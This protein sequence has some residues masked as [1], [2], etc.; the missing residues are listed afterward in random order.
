MVVESK[1]ISRAI[2]GSACCCLSSMWI[3]GGAVC[4]SLPNPTSS[5]LWSAPKSHRSPTRLI[6]QSVSYPTTRVSFRQHYGSEAD[7]PTASYTPTIVPVET[8]IST[9]LLQQHLLEGF[10]AHRTLLNSMDLQPAFEQTVELITSNSRPN[11]ETD[12]A[13]E[14]Q[15][16]SPPTTPIISVLSDVWKARLLLLLS[17]ALYGTNFTLVKSIDEINGMSVGMASTLRFG[18]AALAMLPLLFAPIDAELKLMT[19]ERRGGGG[20]DGNILSKF[21]EEPTRLSAG[22]AGMEIGLYNSIGYLAQAVGLKTTTASKVSSM[23]VFF[24]YY[25]F[26]FALNLTPALHTNVHRVHSFAQWRWLLFRF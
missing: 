26:L 11:D 13:T 3:A 8:E 15:S 6:S 14:Q 25:L 21:W 19:K 24:V 1:M 20:A 2:V 18:F 5:F 16:S 17:A 4:L 22:L 12:I 7:Q 10:I 9:E 23:L